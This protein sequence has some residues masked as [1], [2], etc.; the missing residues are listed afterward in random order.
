VKPGGEGPRRE[1]LA[2]EDRIESKKGGL[3][4][5]WPRLRYNCW[6]PGGHKEVGGLDLAGE[7]ILEVREKRPGEHRLVSPKKVFFYCA[8]RKRTILGNLSVAQV[9]VP[10]EAGHFGNLPHG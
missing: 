8:M 7:G 10:F 5:D 3:G 9:L 1:I 6:P 2:H 4:R